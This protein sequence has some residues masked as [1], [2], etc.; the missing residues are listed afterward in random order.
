MPVPFICIQNFQI[1]FLLESGTTTL[2]GGRR[3]S[4]PLYSHPWG[5]RGARI[6]FHT[7]FFPSLLSSE[8]AFSGIS[9]SLVEE[10]FSGGKPP[11]P[12]VTIESLGN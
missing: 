3:G 5:A 8:G 11:D 10:N 12:Q 2:G 7:E 9:D 6:G 1:E 4:C